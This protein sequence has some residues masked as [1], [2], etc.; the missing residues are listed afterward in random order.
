MTERNGNREAGTTFNVD[1]NEEYI[2]KSDAAFSWFYKYDPTADGGGMTRERMR[3][4]SGLAPG[5]P[6]QQVIVEA[7]PIDI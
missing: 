4:A 7:S 6:E 1:Q 2:L 3:N 5:V